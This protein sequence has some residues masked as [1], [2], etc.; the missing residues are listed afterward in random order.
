MLERG[1][2]DEEVHP[3]RS[4]WELNCTHV[5]DVHRSCLGELY[6]KCK[7]ETPNRGKGASGYVGREHRRLQVGGCL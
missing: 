3:R 5:E 6:C 1:R 2:R 4:G 7:G